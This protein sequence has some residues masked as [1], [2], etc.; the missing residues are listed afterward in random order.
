MSF[1]FEI[2]VGKQQAHR[3]VFP[4]ARGRRELR[5][6]D[7]TLVGN[8]ILDSRGLRVEFV[9]RAVEKLVQSKGAM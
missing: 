6:H 7:G 9:E 2:K 3:V 8:V 4:V 5:A 1:I